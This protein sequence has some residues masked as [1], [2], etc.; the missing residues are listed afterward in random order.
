[1]LFPLYILPTYQGS[2]VKATMNK[3][4]IIGDF[5]R[6]DENSDDIFHTGYEVGKH[7]ME[8]LNRTL[9]SLVLI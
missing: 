8:V 9:R 1:M 2:D 4:Q 3:I 6:L 5:G 7:C